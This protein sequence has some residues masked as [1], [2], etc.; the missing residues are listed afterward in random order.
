MFDMTSLMLFS[1][2]SCHVNATENNLRTSLISNH[3]YRFGNS[4][5]DRHYYQRMSFYFQ[6]SSYS[7][8]FG[9]TKKW[10]YR[11][12]NQHQKT[13]N[14]NA[15]LDMMAIRFGLVK[16]LLWMYCYTHSVK[17][18]TYLIINFVWRFSFLFTS[19]FSCRN[20]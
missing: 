19:L 13:S 7:Q 2:N 11:Y 12:V 16:P 14:A 15:V 5:D 1:I 18:Y 8:Y 3:S 17:N 9:Q 6:Y 20:Y 10:Y 4:F